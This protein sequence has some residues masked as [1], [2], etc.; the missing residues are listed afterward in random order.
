MR[1]SRYDLHT[2]SMVSDGILRPADLVARADEAGI[3]VLALTDHDTT[4]GLA[5]ALEA[6]AGRELRL[7]PGVEISVTWNRRTVHVVGLFIDSD[8]G[9]LR[10]GLAKLKEFRGWRAREIAGR[11][12]KYG[13]QG[14]YEGARELA[15]GPII[16]RTHFARYLVALG[17]AETVRDVF[18]HFLVRNKPGHVSGQWGSLE[19]VLGWIKEAGGQAVIAHPARYRITA[20]KRRELLGEFKECG[21]T[22]IEVI[23][24]SHTREESRVMAAHARSFGFL[25]SVGSDYHGHEIP[26]VQLG[27]L[28]DLPGGCAPI[29]EEWGKFEH[30]LS[31]AVAKGMNTGTGIR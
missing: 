12:E 5:E 31:T 29:W 27:T 23:T 22:G 25:A 1:H 2:H 19:D 30:V 17:Y 13:I 11:L 15:R 28:P 16:S 24:G 6:A 14:A 26:P 9:V 3:R 21:G 4:D 8:C 7:V 10:E 18:R 20:T